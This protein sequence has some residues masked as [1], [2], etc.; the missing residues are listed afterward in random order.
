[1]TLLQMLIKEAFQET[2][3]SPPPMFSCGIPKIFGIVILVNIEGQ[4]EILQTL[5]ENTIMPRLKKET[6]C[7]NFC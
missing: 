1:M 6:A 4:L 3:K 2:C 7:S 5:M